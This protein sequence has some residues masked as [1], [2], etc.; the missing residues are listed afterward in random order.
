LHDVTVVTP[1]YH[2]GRIV[3]LFAN[4]CHVV[5]IG[6]RGFGPDAS[7]VFEEGVNIPIMHLFRRGEVNETLISILETNVREPG[8]V[9]GDIYAFAGANDIGSERLVAMMEEF[10]QDD[11]SDLG[12]FII[13]NSRLATIERI[14][15][16]KNGSF[17]NVL[18]MDGYD[19]PVTLSAELTVSDDNIHVDYTGTSPASRYG[20]NVVLNYTKAYTCFGVKCV[21]AP[22]IP[23]NYGSL[24]PITFHAPEG[25]IL[26]VQRP[27]AVA[28]RHIIGHL[29][30]DTVLGCL[31]QVL[32]E[33]CQAEGS[34]S[35][36]NLQLRGGVATSAKSGYQGYV[37][38]FDLLHFNS[39]GMGARPTKDGLSSTAF[40]SGIRGIPVEV[41]EAI[42]PIVF[43]RKEFR[44]GSGGAGQFRGGCGQVME[45][46][47]VDDIPFDVLAMYERV[48]NAPRGRNG[49]HDGAAGRVSLTDGKPMRSKGQQ[50]IPSGTHLVLEMAGG[51]GFGDPAA[52]DS[53]R[54]AED[55]RN[56]LI[57]SE[58]AY[59]D[60]KVALND[61]GSVDKRATQSLRGVS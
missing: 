41:T 6:G 9:V 37:P 36:W 45:V 57:T 14:A 47:G 22:D 16:L 31:H 10:G 19:K 44:E 49:G 55:V 4:T 50:H 2:K 30:P 17:C 1:T 29:L 56:E 61:D 27:F 33:G 13:E 54:V 39:G 24:L 3:A 38:E 20:I 28:A 12:E 32:E 46:G 52:R 34:A 51:G 25:C 43:W 21:V 35:M 42:T 58:V 5:D 40:P 26:N 53:E 8:Q 23:N 48:D 59:V 7:Q 11:L 18:I 15:K 60:Y